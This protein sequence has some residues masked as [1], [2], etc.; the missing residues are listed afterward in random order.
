MLLKIRK[1]AIQP[2]PI[3]PITTVTYSDGK[4]YLYVNGEKV[5]ESSTVYE[6]I[7]KI[8][9]YDI[10]VSIPNTS[11]RI[12]N[13]KLRSSNNLTNISFKAI[14]HTD[15][16][17]RK[18]GKVLV[19]DDFISN[20]LNANLY[21]KQTIS[22][23]PTTTFSNGEIQI[24]STALGEV[25]YLWSNPPPVFIAELRVSSM[26]VTTA[27]A[28]GI[29]LFKDS[30]NFILFNYV[31]N[32]ANN[33]YRFEVFV[34]KNGTGNVKAYWNANINP[35]YTLIVLFVC[36]AVSLLYEKDN[37]LYYVGKYYITDF[38]FRDPATY[39]SFKIGFGSFVDNATVVHDR[40]AVY[41]SAL[42][43]RDQYL[44]TLWDGVTPVQYKGKYL[45]SA[46]ASAPEF[47]DSYMVL[48]SYDPLTD[49][50]KV[51]SVILNII[52]NK[53]YTD[54]AGQI[55]YDPDNNRFTVFN[56]SWSSSG[57][58]VYSLVYIHYY[59]FTEIKDV[60]T[61][62]ATRIQTTTEAYDPAPRYDHVNNKYYIFCE[63]GAPG[64]RSIA[65]IS[66]TELKPTGWTVE[67]RRME[68]SGEIAEGTHLA[69]IGG[70]LYLT[71][72]D[73]QYTTDLMR[74][75]EFKTPFDDNL[76]NYTP[77]ISAKGLNPPHPLIIPIMDSDTTIYKLVTFTQSLPPVGT[78]GT[79]YVYQSDKSNIGY[80]T[81]KVIIQ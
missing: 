53:L 48:L 68:P 63:Y 32:P 26:S 41:I 29:Y 2:I 27:G 20:P 38:D 50:I 80:E 55:I 57:Y 69:S 52:N 3:I 62:T 7:Q 64:D 14:R 37:K 54:H 6:L 30:N 13:R 74:Y 5:Y 43:I 60:I 76:I 23:S 40:F 21:E 70:K 15:V 10:D 47:K 81:P 39:D 34:K 79:L 28:S 42:G 77:K 18:I 4:Y 58:G 61:G 17:F 9:D 78:V 73:S 24:S 16:D 22:G 71:W 49:D 19:Y 65:L 1:E 44:V 8:K 46:T 35:P 33:F 72:T 25:T 59:H 45:I 36:G 56:S 67:Y 11:L 51:L 75:S 12:I 66:N 31:R